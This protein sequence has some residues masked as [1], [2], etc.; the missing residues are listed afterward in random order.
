M[1]DVN[2]NMERTICIYNA[3]RRYDDN[4]T[5]YMLVFEIKLQFSLK[6]S[7]KKIYIVDVIMTFAVIFTDGPAFRR[8]N[9]NYTNKKKI[10]RAKTFKQFKRGFVSQ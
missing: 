9:D 2:E 7:T 6:L 3:V 5:K 8:S 10:D 4:I 1:H